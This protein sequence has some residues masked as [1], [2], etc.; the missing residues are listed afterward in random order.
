MLKNKTILITGGGS[1]IG[2]ALAINLSIN[3][4]V[5]ICGR[6]EQKLRRVAAR[7]VDISFYKAD[8]SKADGIDDLFTK[9][10]NDKIVL[11]V[12][13]NNAGVVEA[14]DIPNVVLSTAQIFE[15]VSTNLTGA[16]AVTQKFIHQA[17][18][19]IEN[20]IVNITSEVALFPIPILPLY[21]TSKAGLRVFTQ[22]LRQQ[23]KDTNFKVVEI[24]PPAVD[25]A[26]PRQLG[27]TEKGLNAD[28]FVY[29]I[30]KSIAKG[31]NEYAP[32]SNVILL[33]LFKNFFPKVGLQLID[34]MSRKQLRLK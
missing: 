21:S 17:N 32:G 1:G 31:K 28:D 14:W 26:M 5:I 29:N 33:K 10:S 7:N 34:K 13:F 12:L 18:K 20:I 9:L 22:S 19:S 16:I 2:E 3:N 8:V 6:D 24:L 15:K 4:R 27:N 30:L 11:D 25:T 23:M